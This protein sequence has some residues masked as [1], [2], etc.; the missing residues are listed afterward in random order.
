MATIFLSFLGASDYQPV[1]YQ[2]DRCRTK[3][4]RKYVQTASIEILEQHIDKVLLLCT[5][6]AR[7][8]HERDIKDEIA[9]ES[10]AEVE[11]ISI[12]D[13]RSEKELWTIFNNIGEA[14]S[15]QN[16]TDETTSLIVDVTHG[17]RSLPTVGILAL[18]FYRHLYKVKIERVLYGAFEALVDKNG[19]KPSILG[20]NITK[21]LN[22]LS[23][24]EREQYTAPILDLT[25]ML[26]LSSWAEAATEWDRTGRSARLLELSKPYISIIQRELKNNTPRELSALP[27]KLKLLDDS[28]SLL[29]HDKIAESARDFIII[30]NNAKEHIRNIDRLSP[31]DAALDNLIENVEPLSV[32]SDKNLK[33]LSHEYLFNQVSIAKWHAEHGRVVESVSMVREIMTSCTASIVHHLNLSFGDE[34]VTSENYRRSAEFVLQ[35]LCEDNPTKKRLLIL[36]HS[37]QLVYVCEQWLAE[38]IDFKNKYKSAVSRIT[39]VRN[40]LDHCWHGKEAEN[41]NRSSMN[42]VIQKLNKAIVDLTDIVD[43]ISKSDFSV[44]DRQNQDT[45]SDY[46]F[47]N[48]SNH[49]IDSWS[50]KQR[51]EAQNLNLGQPTDLPGGMPIVSPDIS[52]EEVSIMAKEIFDRV[53]TLNVKGAFVAGE[54]TLSYALVSLLTSKGIRCFAAT[55]ARETVETSNPDG[56]VNRSAVF[57]FVKWREYIK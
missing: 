4:M 21:Y 15:S 41:F 42:D 27:E 12:P 3:K 14:L 55:T 31:L 17:F 25:S 47:I 46:I 13:G 28:L 30:A 34:P 38:N 5:N 22:E 24:Q 48:L 35:D 16:T 29:R 9:K 53:L 56:S 26:E 51:Q 54:P 45:K 57:K 19:D 40:R 52:P 32:G 18:S 2:L 10:K 37:E 23:G 11:I 49:L 20:T 6:G 39:E 1:N 36:K 8:K 7:Q 44:K 43:F 33:I 50:N